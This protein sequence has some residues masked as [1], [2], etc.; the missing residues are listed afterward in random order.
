MTVAENRGS[1]FFVFSRPSAAVVVASGFV[2]AACA[3]MPDLGVDDGSGLGGPRLEPFKISLERTE[4]G[5]IAGR[6]YD[7]FTNTL[8]STSCV[9]TVITKPSYSGI[10]SMRLSEAADEVS[11]MAALGVGVEAQA[12]AYGASASGRSE[13]A[14]DAAFLDEEPDFCD[15]REDRGAASGRNSARRGAQRTAPSPIP[16]IAMGRGGLTSPTSGSTPTVVSCSKRRISTSFGGFAATASF[17][18]FT[19]AISFG[20]KLRCAMSQPH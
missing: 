17:T 9:D 12:T 11:L 18:P 13:F 20:E 6:A 19:A 10:S 2:L 3:N 8:L 5:D 15:Q 14:L 4:Q 16:A 1:S 7:S